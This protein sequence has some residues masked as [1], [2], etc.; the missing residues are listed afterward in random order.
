MFGAAAFAAVVGMGGC[1]TLGAV[2]FTLAAIALGALTGV[3]EVGVG[4]P[5][6]AA[7][8]LRSFAALRAWPIVATGSFAA[9]VVVTFAIGASLMIAFG[10]VAFGWRVAVEADAFEAAGL[11]GF[12]IAWTRFE[13]ALAALEPFAAFGAART[14]FK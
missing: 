7:L 13:G 1:G 2:A 6:F 3:A 9:G 5:L 12:G 8:S 4:W 11:A 10:A 14:T